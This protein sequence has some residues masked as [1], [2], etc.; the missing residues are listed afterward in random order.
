MK[1]LTVDRAGDAILV[2]VSADGF[3]YHMVRIIAGTLADCAL[4]SRDPDEIPAAL[5]AMNRS[6]AG[7]T[8]PACGLYLAAVDYGTPVPWRCD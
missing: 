2:T 1:S 4:G 7:R 3:L 8:A 6:K 5:E